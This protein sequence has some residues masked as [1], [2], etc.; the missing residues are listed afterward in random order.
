MA[1]PWEAFQTPAPTG[2][3]VGPWQR[4]ADP[5]PPRGNLEEALGGERVEDAFNNLPDRDLTAAMQQRAAQRDTSQGEALVTSVMKGLTFGFDDEV[6]AAVGTALGLSES[7]AEALERIRAQQEQ[8]RTAYPGTSLA[9]ELVGGLGTGL[10]AARTGLTW[11]GRNYATKSTAGRM[12]A[13]G[14]EGAAYGAVY[15]AGNAE[16]GLT[17]RLL[18]GAIGGVAGAGL[19]AAFPLAGKGMELGWRGVRRPVRSTSDVR[20]DTAARRVLAGFNAD[21]IAPD[22]IA[23]RL[24]ALRSEGQPAVVADAGGETVRALARSAGNTS[25]AARDN[26]LDTV[27][28]RGMEQSERVSDYLLGM[29]GN[30]NAAQVRDTLQTA[31]RQANRPAYDLAYS[32]GPSVWNADLERL[33]ASPDVQ[34]AIQR[35]ERLSANESALTGAPVPPTPF[36]RDMRTGRMTLRVNPDGST[37]V[38]SLQFWDHVQRGLRDVETTASRSGANFNASQAGNLRRQL[39]E[40]LDSAVPEFQTARRGAAGFFGAEDALEAGRAFVGSKSNEE[41]ARAILNMSPPEQQLFRIGYA[42]ELATR[43][44]QMASNRDVT[45][46]SLLN[47]PHAR[48][49]MTLAL[50][51]QDARALE[52]FLTVEQTMNRLRKAVGSGSDTFRNFMQAGMAGGLGGFS[53]TGDPATAAASFLLS[54]AFRRGV[55]GIDQRVSNEVAR[56]LTSTDATELRRGL[57]MAAQHPLIMDGI[58]RA[59][60]VAIRLG[61]QAVPAMTQ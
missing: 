44:R 9:G 56:L 28:S 55:Q 60:G 25:S 58:R 34:R 20:A 2:P 7:Y 22:Q 61:A 54:A 4:Y 59:E 57:G 11:M 5:Q 46:S 40:A 35:A 33:T 19:G 41:S 6:A 27:Q 23:P 1:G 24:A 43:I 31:A 8:E 14:G 15:G 51:P 21:R 16:G 18:S 53:L 32:R 42:D 17:D 29:T 3:S 36:V 39:N 48:Q 12:S 45:V 13:A 30:A 52:G 37:A 38:P 47:S 26:L 49:Q 10:G 50:G